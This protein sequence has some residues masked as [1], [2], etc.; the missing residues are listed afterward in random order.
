LRRRIRPI[1]ASTASIGES[2]RAPNARDSSATVAHT[3]SIVVI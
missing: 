3:G 2:V 1:S